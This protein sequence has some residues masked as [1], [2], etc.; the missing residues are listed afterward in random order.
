M[1]YL[2]FEEDALILFNQ[3]IKKVLCFRYSPFQIVN[4]YLLSLKQTT[5]EF[6]N[7]IL[8][9]M[10]FQESKLLLMYLF[11][12][13][14]NRP[15]LVVILALLLFFKLRRS[16]GYPLY[17]NNSWNLHSIVLK[18]RSRIWLNCLMKD[19]I[20]TAISTV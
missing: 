15:N 9:S 7:L 16:T 12:L 18:R 4:Q 5:L 19:V 6:V 2:C 14:L 3:D 13:L 11:F 8:I 17:G 10:H 20:T 1:N